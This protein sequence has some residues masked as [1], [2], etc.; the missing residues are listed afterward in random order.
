MPFM[1]LHFND[2]YDEKTYAS[3]YRDGDKLKFLM[4][5]TPEK[6]DVVTTISDSLTPHIKVVDITAREVFG[7]IPPRPG[8][9]ETNPDYDNF[10]SLFV[11]AGYLSYKKIYYDSSGC[12]GSF[13]HDEPEDV[14]QGTLFL[15]ELR[16]KFEEWLSTIP[17]K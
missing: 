16:R 17:E 11:G 5:K 6:D 15:Q 4:F 8:Y 12:R 14:E 3:I 10:R 1:K 13:G 7:I 9:G 2:L